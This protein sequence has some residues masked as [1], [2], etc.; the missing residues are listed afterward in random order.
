MKKEA[1]ASVSK[2]AL[3]NG[4]RLFSIELRERI[5]KA[6]HSARLLRPKD[7]HAA[8][9]LECEFWS[10]GLHISKLPMKLQTLFQ[11]RATIL[12]AVPGGI[13]LKSFITCQKSTPLKSDYEALLKNGLTSPE[14]RRLVNRT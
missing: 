6:M 7:V 13:C 1:Q 3:G 10:L 14:N 11:E 5:E 4:S 9:W 12:R 8:F 2:I